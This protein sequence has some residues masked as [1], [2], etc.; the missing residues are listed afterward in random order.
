MYYIASRM[1]NISI[2]NAGFIVG[3]TMIFHSQCRGLRAQFRTEVLTFNVSS[4]LLLSLHQ[5]L[6]QLSAVIK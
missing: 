3:V 4:N 5:T 6:I 1:I 2:I